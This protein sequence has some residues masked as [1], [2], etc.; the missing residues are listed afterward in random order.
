[1]TSEQLPVYL[2]LGRSSYALTIFSEDELATIRPIERSGK[3]YLEC[4]ASGKMRLAKPEEVVR[5]LY[6]NRL[7][8][9]YG[10]PEDR[11]AVERAVYFG[12]T[13]HK[14]A[15]DIVVMDKDDPNAAYI[16]VEVKK[17]KRRDGEEQLKSYC[18]AEGSPIGV[19]T[20]GGEELILHRS[21][22]NIFRSL[23]A[24]P[25]AHQTLEDLLD[26]R[27][28]LDDL[29]REN[30]LVREKTTLKEI[31]LSME[32]LV[33]ANAG[34]DAF[35]E[36][37][38]LIYAKLFDESESARRRTRKLEFRAG[39]STPNDL[40][41]RINA[42]F[43]KAKDRWPGVF[44]DGERIDLAPNHLVTCVSFLQD[45]KLFNSNL[46]VIDE[47]FEYLS[48]EVGKGKKGQ[49]FTPRHAIDMCVKML[50]P[51]YDEYV[52][53]T[54]AGSCGFTVHSIFHVW[55]DEFSAA[56]PEPWQAEFAREKAYAIDFDPRSIKIAKALNLIAG[57]G[58]TN[59]Y[60][61]NTL[62]P[63]NWSDDVRVGLQPR[64]A[65]L[66]NHQQDRPNRERMRL[67]DFDL[68]L[69]NPPF[70]GELVD[71]RL[72]HQYDIA[73]KS[74]GTWPTSIGRDVLFI[75]RNL[76]FLRPGGRMA[77]VLPQGR[78]NNSS[79]KSLRE[80]ITQHARILA[81]VGLQ[82]NTF[83]PHTGTKTSV[84][85]LQKWNEDPSRGPLCPRVDDYPV[86]FATS[87]LSGKDNRGDYQY[88]KSESREVLTDL[89]D[90]PILEHDL[91]DM[92]EVVKKQFRRLEPLCATSSD[93]E[94]LVARRDELLARLPERETIAEAF[95]RWAQQQGFAFAQGG[96]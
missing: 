79:E 72:I 3:L 52:I 32:D 1:M 38:K 25:A 39:L 58:R 94:S 26:E 15:A 66:G 78:L 36:V 37:F 41:E 34:V 27:W 81:V 35:E 62:D 60:R 76:Q 86:F 63:L 95:G 87:Q 67:F 9:V 82:V 74:N 29:I 7:I 21:N 84:L 51:T 88:L 50:N 10:Y 17:P 48:T 18:N 24:L 92:R 55:G 68:V 33:L 45:V 12:S 73:Q 56:G 20:N 65:K 91:F 40:Y 5:Q 42:L 90:H 54:A 11:I 47:A 30:K 14:K 57:D 80:W 75:E 96:K 83:K 4:L 59:V 71:S 64:L 19:W 31:V 22:P 53:D 93:R 70:A 6:I 13:V 46:Q 49:Y 2:L 85:F 23:S 28:T 89:Y 61:A 69:T 16:I 44:L 43:L 8:N 77:I